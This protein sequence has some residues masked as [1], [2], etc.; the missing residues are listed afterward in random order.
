VRKIGGD[1][2]QLSVRC[3]RQAAL[4]ALLEGIVVEPAGEVLG[5]QQLG[6]RLAVPIARPEAFRAR[7]S[8]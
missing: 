8:R 6:D 1:R 5:A 2:V 4:E 3:R 7:G